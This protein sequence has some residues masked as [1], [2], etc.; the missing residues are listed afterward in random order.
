MTKCCHI[1][2][3]LYIKIVRNRAQYLLSIAVHTN[4]SEAVK[5]NYYVV[6]QH[7]LTLCSPG[8]TE[9]SAPFTE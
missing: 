5:F 3:T 6:L 7:V 1:N 4:Y 8:S 2:I 9:N